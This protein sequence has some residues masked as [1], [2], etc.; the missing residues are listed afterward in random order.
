M[1]TRF[2]KLVVYTL[3][4][5]LLWASIGLAANKDSSNPV[6]QLTG[7]LWM[8]SRADMKEA[9]LFGVECTIAVEHFVAEEL[10]K[11]AKKGKRASTHTLSPFEK[12]W[13]TVFKGVSRESIAKQ[14]DAWYAAH[15]DKLSRPVFDVIWY[16]LIAPKLASR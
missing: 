10:A 4:L 1:Y 12:G 6:E 9:F 14:V 3:A 15:P 11:K 2:L 8:Q 5:T 7:T 13:S 16:E